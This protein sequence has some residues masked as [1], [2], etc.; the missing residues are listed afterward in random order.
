MEPYTWFYLLVAAIA[1]I[2]MCIFW[3]SYRRVKSKKLLITAMAFSIFF[4]KAI[5]MALEVVFVIVVGAED[6]PEEFWISL[7]AVLDIVIITLFAVP[8][9]Q[10][11]EAENG[12]G[13]SGNRGTNGV[14]APGDEVEPGDRTGPDDLD[15]RSRPGTV[16]EPEPNGNPEPETGQEPGSGSGQ[17][18]ADIEP[19]LNAEGR[20]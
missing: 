16:G 15:A 17:D 11:P 20:D 18:L 9:L 8:L 3:I 7:A 5:I 1:L 14:G 10:K 4:V 13:A 2:P 19:E 6:F 12:N